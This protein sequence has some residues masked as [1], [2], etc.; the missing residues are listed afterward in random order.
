M[1]IEIKKI[2]NTDITKINFGNEKDEDTNELT[3]T[4]ELDIENQIPFLEQINSLLDEGVSKIILTL[5]QISYIDS[6]GLWAIFESFKKA[7]QRNGKIVLLNPK[8]DVRRVLDITKI[9]S[10]IK[11]FEEDESA[12]TYLS[13]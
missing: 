5:S 9:S 11:I 7:E 13:E 6:S 3:G 2:S 12:I 10:K 4:I 8:K 1:E